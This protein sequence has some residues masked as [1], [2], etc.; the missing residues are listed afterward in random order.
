MPRNRKSDVVDGFN[1]YKAAQRAAHE[2]KA[3]AEKAVPAPAEPEA[4]KKIGSHIGRTVLPSKHDVTC[5][6]CGYDFQLTGAVK[7]TYCSKCR[8]QI[9][10][11]NFTIKD[12][13]TEDIKTAGTVT[14]KPDGDVVSGTIKAN[15]IIV[16]GQASG[17]VLQAF[18]WLEL[19]SST[20]FDPERMTSAHLLI[21]PDAH[22]ILPEVRYDEITV[23]GTL[24]AR[25]FASGL[26]RIMDGG[27][28]EGEVHGS[29]L[30]VED[31]GSL[32]A[33]VEVRPRGKPPVDAEDDVPLGKTA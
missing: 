33:E 22:L 14:I 8:A 9:A 15:H 20:S 7:S 1:V 30:A 26:V 31:G 21:G 11:E 28:V 32:R 3:P 10:V 29:Q 23:H 4:Q 19:R 6:E 24:K 27:R 2:K 17:G 16:E 25:V 18:R 12:E 5:Y 13:W